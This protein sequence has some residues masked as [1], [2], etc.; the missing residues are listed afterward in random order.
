MSEQVLDF[1]VIYADFRPRI[2]RYLTRLVG[3]YDA[4]DLT[5]EVFAKISRALPAFRGESQLSTWIYRIATN[6]AMD[7][8]GA[9]AFRTTA[10]DR[11]P[12]GPESDGL[13]DETIP[14]G[15]APGSV[16]AEVC[17][18]QRYEC[19]RDYIDNLPPN[20][21]TIVFLSEWGE[22][23]VGEIADLLGLSVGTVKIRLHRGRLRLLEALKQ[24]CR[25][26]DWL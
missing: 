7:R 13:G 9:P 14:T 26:E 19:Y 1:D 24:H 25:A 10:P 20:Y 12:G 18:R 8:L 11:P 15:E 3:E 4:E 6:A 21:R 17:R 16:E 22:L 2:L 5:Q 23:A